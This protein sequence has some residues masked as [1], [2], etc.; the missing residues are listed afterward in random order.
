VEKFAMLVK[1][2]LFGPIRKNQFIAEKGLKKEKN[3]LK[4]LIL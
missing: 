4:M 3:S 2:A 1:E